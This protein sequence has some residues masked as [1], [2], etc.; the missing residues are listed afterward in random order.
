VLV[1]NERELQTPA[2]EEAVGTIV[3]IEEELK[4]HLDAL[5]RW[6]AKNKAK[7]FIHALASGEK[8]EKGLNDIL[9]RAKADLSMRITTTHVGLSGTIRDGFSA[10]LSIVR[11]V[12][13]NV[14]AVLGERLVIASRLDGRESSST[15]KSPCSIHISNICLQLVSERQNHT[16]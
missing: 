15:G 6:R 13:E 7:Q 11:R 5:S 2:I 12:D 3:A 14:Q 16:Q 8:D 4:T 1:Q 9:D 10:A